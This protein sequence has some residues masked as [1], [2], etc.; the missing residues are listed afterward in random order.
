MIFPKRGVVEVCIFSNLLSRRKLQLSAAFNF[1][2]QNY[3]IR[4]GD[5]VARPEGAPGSA[6]NFFPTL[7]MGG[8]SRAS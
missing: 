1:S 7:N 6:I 3:T 8:T 2:T 5:R 4:M